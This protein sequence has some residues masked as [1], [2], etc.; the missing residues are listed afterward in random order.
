MYV[1]DILHRGC[2]PNNKPKILKESDSTAWVDA[3]DVLGATAG[4][5]AMD[6]AIQKACDSGIG[7]I[8]VKGKHNMNIK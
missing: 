1:N 2:K 6:L 5:F 8:S 3:N 7:W 4:H